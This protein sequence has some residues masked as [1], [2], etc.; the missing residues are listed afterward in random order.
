MGKLQ[1]VEDVLLLVGGLNHAALLLDLGHHVVDA[2][3]KQGLLLRGL[4][5]REVPKRT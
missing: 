5:G 1:R 3:I 2:V 4:L